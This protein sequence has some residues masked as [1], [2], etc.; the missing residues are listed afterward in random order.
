ML[1]ILALTTAAG[2]NIF[3]LLLGPAVI[4]FGFI[5]YIWMLF[6]II[7]QPIR[8]KILWFLIV[9]FLWLPGALLYYLVGRK[10]LKI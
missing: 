2:R 4:G 3:L 7:K 9:F 1:S 5:F 10:Q 6:D 8:S